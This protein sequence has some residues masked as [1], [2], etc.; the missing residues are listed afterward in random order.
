[1]LGISRCMSVCAC[2]L[3]AFAAHAEVIPTGINLSLD[4]AS[5]AM[6]PVDYD[7]NGGSIGREPIDLYLN[8]LRDFQDIYFSVDRLALGLAGSPVAMLAAPPGSSPGADVFVLRGTGRV[9]LFTPA[10]ALGL[11][12]SFFGDD[13][14]GLQIRS[15]VAGDTINKPFSYNVIWRNSTMI[16]KA[17]SVSGGGPGGNLLPSDIL[18]GLTDKVFAR[19]DDMGLQAGD[20][21]DALIL[22]DVTPD[23]REPRGY[24]LR[25]DGIVDPGFDIAIFSLDP[26]SPSTITGGGDDPTLTPGTLLLTKFDGT[27]EV[28]L[29]PEQLG[30]KPFDNVDGLSLV[31]EPGTLLGVLV[32]LAALVAR[33]RRGGGPRAPRRDNH[34]GVRTCVFAA[35]IGAII[36]PLE[37][38]DAQAVLGKGRYC[39]NAPPTLPSHGL[40]D[41]SWTSDGKVLFKVTASAPVSLNEKLVDGSILMDPQTAQTATLLPSAAA[42]EKIVFTHVAE[43]GG[44]TFTFHGDVNVSPTGMGAAV[45]DVTVGGMGPAVRYVMADMSRYA[46]TARLS[47]HEETFAWC[48]GEERS[49]FVLIDKQALNPP[50][51]GKVTI[52]GLE[53]P[54][55]EFGTFT[56]FPNEKFD[57]TAD[58]AWSLKAGQEPPNPFFL[59]I[60]FR[61]TKFK[62]HVAPVEWTAIVEVQVGP[63][64]AALPPDHGFGSPPGVA[65]FTT[66]QIE[67]AFDDGKPVVTDATMPPKP[68]TDLYADEGE[69]ASAV[70][71][72]TS[73]CT[74]GMLTGEWT[75]TGGEGKYAIMTD[76]AQPQALPVKFAIPPF[77]TYEKKIKLTNIA[78][79]KDALPLELK[80]TPVEA[81]ACPPPKV[82]VHF[83]PPKVIELNSRYTRRRMGQEPIHASY[84]SGVSIFKTPPASFNDVYTAKVDWNGHTPGKV[85]FKFGSIILEGSEP[86]PDGA[87]MIEFQ[88]GTLPIGSKVRA[89][90]IAQPDAPGGVGTKSKELDAALDLVKPPFGGSTLY[91]HVFQ[92]V[93]ALSGSPPELKYQ[94]PFLGI[95]LGNIAQFPSSGSTPAVPKDQ[96]KIV[97]KTLLKWSPVIDSKIAVSGTGHSANIAVAA[98]VGAEKDAPAAKALPGFFKFD[99]SAFAKLKKFGF[100][101]FQIQL[102]WG[103]TYD[104]QE[105]KT[106]WAEKSGDWGLKG[107]LS[108]NA[109][110][111]PVPVAVI[112]GVPVSLQGV[113]GLAADFVLNIAKIPNPPENPAYTGN[114]SITP[115]GALKVI[116]G[117]D[118]IATLEGSI[119]LELPVAVKFP[120]SKKPAAPLENISLVIVGKVTFKALGTFEIGLLGGS[121]FFTL[122]CP[123]TQ[124]TSYNPCVGGSFAFGLPPPGGFKFKPT[125]RDYLG[126]DFAGFVGGG[127]A[128]GQAPTV[129]NTI[130]TNEFRYSEPDITSTGTTRLLAWTTDDPNRA[131]VNRSMALYSRAV[132]DAW[133]VPAPIDDDGTPDFNPQIRGI[134]ATGDALAAWMNANAALPE[135]ATLGDLLASLDISTATYSGALGVWTPGTALTSNGHLDHKPRLALAPDGGALLVWV[136]NP[137]NNF[138]GSPSQPNMIMY[139]LLSG[140]VWSAPAIAA[141]G[142]PAISSLSAA[143][144]G[145]EAVVA[146][147][148]DSDGIFDPE[149]E[150]W[151]EELFALQFDGSSWSAPQQ[152]TDD[153]VQDSVPTVTYDSTGVPL[154]VWNRDDTIVSARQLD[155]SDL[156]LATP[157]GLAG[158]RCAL[159]TGT[160][161]TAALVWPRALNTAGDILYAYFDPVAGAWSFPGR[162]TE[163]EAHETALSATIDSDGR[164]HC[165]YMA[166]HQVDTIEKVN[167]QGEIY[168]IVVPVVDSA[169]LMVASVEFH[170][171]LAITTDQIAFDPPT[172]V[173]GEELTITATIEN[174]GH[175]AA[176]GTDVAFYD[177]DPLAGGVL[178]G[179]QTISS[180]IGGGDSAEASI[181][182]IVPDDAQP[183]DVYVVV[184]P[185]DE[186]DDID[187]DNNVASRAAVAA[188][189]VID[190]VV[191]ESGT[192]CAR[193][194]HFTVVNAG[195][196]AAP[197]SALTL[198]AGDAGGPLLAEF[199][200]DALM[201]GESQEFEFSWD[202]P[203]VA[204][205]GR[206]HLYATVDEA[207]VIVELDEQNANA[208]SIGLIGM[209]GTDCNGNGVSDQ[210]DLAS[211][212]SLDANGNDIPDE[213]EVLYVNADAAPNGNGK[214]WDSAFT[215]LQDA[216]AAAK[217]SGGAVRQVWVASGTYAPAEPGGDRTASF[218]MPGGVQLFGG[219]AGTETSLSQR[220]LAAPATVLTGDLNGNDAG[221]PDSV[222]DNSHHVVT[223]DNVAANTTLDGFTI[224]SANADGEGPLGAGGGLWVQNGGLTVRNCSFIGN[225]A[226]DGGA[227]V[228]ANAD[229]TFV[230]CVFSGNDGAD[231]G[232]GVY[233]FAGTAALVN[234]TFAGNSTGGSGGGVYVQ[235]GDVQ[236]TG[237]ILWSNSDAGGTDE[238]AQVHVAS[239]T[240][241]VNYS[242]VQGLSG[243]LGGV[244]NIGADPLFAAPVGK[245]GLIGTLD[246]DLRL[247]G[248][249]PAIDAANNAALPADA[250]D[251][252]GD[253]DTSELLPIDR[254]GLPRFKDIPAAPNTGAGKPPLADMG[255]YEKQSAPLSRPPS[256]VVPAPLTK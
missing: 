119:G 121:I 224:V 7:V 105:G 76:E 20:A 235:F 212:T 175:V 255:A 23:P 210:C 176:T 160:D 83:A 47:P 104:I 227:V 183:H 99:P 112:F 231:H 141:T 169:D 40:L 198:R 85:L 77:G 75:I 251:L 203:P 209:E 67:C 243:S 225:A 180:V 18:L 131:A 211:G 157:D 256:K 171:D 42:P 32:G 46:Y 206:A 149:A 194:I 95:P 36:L 19:A 167:W 30:L 31:P 98:G 100:G 179:A 126:P 13:I 142:I 94:V 91:F 6:L 156:T 202:A 89:F 10:E 29:A 25:P 178:I 153:L 237:C 252:D 129:I 44:K 184:D 222:A 102:I 146:Y 166:Q 221:N 72:I 125:P 33:G 233:V 130:V 27:Y 34:S 109:P 182:W 155:L 241:A 2:A 162:L 110:P 134:G 26:F 74:T 151:D 45:L 4:S 118:G 59:T 116:G 22:L 60:G 168:Q 186:Q 223:A 1:M 144:N 96:D 191:P 90:A 69:P 136:A 50:T 240:L 207:D 242:C 138:V 117:F 24:A 187:P 127:V 177:G 79:H 65:E 73:P 12:G 244:G 193:T 64:C 5:P 254:D 234:C 165:A 86:A 93:A 39:G 28:L 97:G 49:Y 150:S 68:G 161:G 208:A 137:A 189:L 214:A 56:I 61:V 216:L 88:T 200:I 143:F 48:A 106:T 113:L 84:L 170:G 58:G 38:A 154:Y 17:I 250:D 122:D 21:I 53:A 190:G 218:E 54:E 3:L 228:A 35:I 217:D 213:C 66:P 205:D 201:P 107:E 247:M 63:E 196:L 128:L 140:G 204:E 124:P 43:A 181:V 158:A 195:G 80:V 185:D 145:T 115:K 147:C 51:S 101:S 152:I 87:T 78:G 192:D 14:D 133:S 246:D 226:F 57:I 172:P 197:A 230:N 238:S 132:T 215:R 249:S 236:L 9:E 8:G 220:N 15:D 239:G 37:T 11:G 253:G 82:H 111:K 232:G 139:S 159:A 163:D 148:G 123:P 16:G 41:V 229:T 199:A 62:A 52:I 188:D 164:L 103:K 92:K 174:L 55:Y 245:D 248:G 173:P 219:F 81:I 120:V 71:R 108:F 70:V 114:I 135:N